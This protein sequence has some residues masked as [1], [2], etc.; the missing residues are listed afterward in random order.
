MPTYIGF[1]I[2]TLLRQDAWLLLNLFTVG[3]DA[4]NSKM[5][6]LLFFLIKKVSKKIKKRGYS[7][8]RFIVL[9][10]SQVQLRLELLSP[11]DYARLPT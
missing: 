3:G 7:S 2:K 11:D 10:A 4:N 1:S 5:L 9:W 8:P 6:L